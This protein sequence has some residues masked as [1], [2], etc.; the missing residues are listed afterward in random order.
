MFKEGKGKGQFANMPKEVEI[1]EWPKYPKAG[2]KELDD[3]ITG[4]DEVCGKSASKRKSK[5][6]NQK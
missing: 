5:V 2:E 3:T 4:I 1:K 6:S